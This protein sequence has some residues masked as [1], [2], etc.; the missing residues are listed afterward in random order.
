LIS[1]DIKKLATKTVPLSSRPV[2][3][4]TVLFS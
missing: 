1:K 3:S 2:E 4:G